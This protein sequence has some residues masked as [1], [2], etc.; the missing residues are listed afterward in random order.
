MT[1]RIAMIGAG[2]F[3]RANHMPALRRLIDADASRLSLEAICDLDESKARAFVEDFG[4]KAA[5][6]DLHEMIRRVE[7]DAVYVLVTPI[8]SAEVIGQ[9][10]PYGLPVFT[11]KPPGV[12]A[13]QAARLA[14]LAEKHGV[15]SYVAFNRR[16]MPAMRRLKEWMTEQGPV[17]F[18]R[19]SL[20]RWRRREPEFATGTAIHPLDAL[21]FLGGDV[22]E[23][24]TEARPYGEGLD[25]DFEVRL[26]FASGLRAS[27]DVIVDTGMHREHYVAFAEG[28]SAEVTVPGGYS[29]AHFPRGF[30]AHE[31]REITADEPA[32]DDALVEAGFLGEHEA[33]L[34]AL[35]RG[36]APDCRLQDAQHSVRLASAVNHEYSGLLADF[37]EPA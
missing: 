15:L 22:V 13:A 5:F 30:R 3:N 14:E 28:R 24:Q 29:S 18:L 32:G 9:V 35:E 26:R 25:R 7:P 20:L 11:E 23:V 6:T 27:L 19:A 36:S 21:R 4:F 34:H 33:F 1:V 2:P 12:T 16:Q 37:E 8:V 17:R 10:L 31:K